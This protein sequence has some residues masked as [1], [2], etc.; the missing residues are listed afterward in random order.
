MA[1]DVDDGERFSL[2]D[3]SRCLNSFLLV[4]EIAECGAEA[5]DVEVSTCC[6]IFVVGAADVS[7]RT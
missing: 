1:A 7:C 4:Y 2:L 6:C 3:A 5:V